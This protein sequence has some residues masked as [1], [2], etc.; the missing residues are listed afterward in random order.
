MRKVEM[1]KIIGI[2]LKIL[3][4]L[5]IVEVGCNFIMQTISYSFYKRAKKMMDLTST[6]Q[7]IQFK[8]GLTGYGNNLDTEKNDKVILFFGGSNYIAYNAV[9]KYSS[10]FD[11]P[12]LAVDFYGT[13]GSGGKMNLATMKQAAED[14]YEWARNRY[15]NSEIIVIGHSYGV[16]MATYLASVKECHALFIVAGYR[17]VSD[18]YN[19]I[20]PVFWG[21]LKVFIS[22]NIP[23]AEYARNVKCP[24]YILGSTGDRVLNASLQAKLASGFENHTLQI[25]NGIAHEDYFHSDTVLS[26]IRQIIN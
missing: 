5:L 16:G 13:Q 19:K 18:L 10:K 1:K 24:V 11:Y 20:T 22:N 21:P 15:P 7:F 4:W 14:L 23:T 25:F 9:G 26:F 12:F 2:L 17:D 8:D 6:P 3:I